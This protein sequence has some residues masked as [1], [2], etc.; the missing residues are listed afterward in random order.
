MTDRTGDESATP[1][2]PT[3]AQAFQAMDAGARAIPGIDTTDPARLSGVT[4]AVF[5]GLIDYLRDP[6]RFPSPAIN[7][8]A[9]E[10]WRLIGNRVVPVALYSVP[11]IAFAVI[12][13]PDGQ[14]GIVLLPYGFTQLVRDDLTMQLGAL[15]N[16]ASQVHDFHAGQIGVASSADIAERAA[17]FEAEALHAIDRVAAAAGS[18]VS[19][20]DYQTQLTSRFPRGLADLRPALA[21][22]SREL[23]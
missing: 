2:L 16:T 1:H 15:V 20:N 12:G 19:W 22:P 8:L 11:S 17:A 7:E 4:V 3:A 10:A 23:L 9:T 5:D 14:Q 13:G 6:E 18:P 21:K